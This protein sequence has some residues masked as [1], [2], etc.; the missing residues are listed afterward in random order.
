MCEHILDKAVV[1]TLA[2]TCL[3][4][5]VYLFFVL[6]FYLLYCINIIGHDSLVKNCLRLKSS[7]PIVFMFIE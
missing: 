5:G 2:L 7:T 1:Q 4:A 3:P 6:L